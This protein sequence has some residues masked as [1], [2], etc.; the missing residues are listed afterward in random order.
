MKKVSNLR[1]QSLNVRNAAKDGVEPIVF[2][3]FVLSV[4]WHLPQVWAASFR[5]RL[6]STVVT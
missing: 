1:R 2:I 4:A 5:H 6:T 3:R